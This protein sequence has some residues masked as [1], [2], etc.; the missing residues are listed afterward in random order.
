VLTWSET[1]DDITFEG[2]RELGFGDHV[3]VEKQQFGWRVSAQLWKWPDA[4]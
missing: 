3:R 1:G 2:R 4:P